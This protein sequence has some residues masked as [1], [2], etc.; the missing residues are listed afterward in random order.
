[1]SNNLIGNCVC[2]YV[3]IRACVKKYLVYVVNS[4]EVLIF[5]QYGPGYHTCWSIKKKTTTYNNCLKLFNVHGSVHPNN[6]V[7]YIS[8]QDAHVTELILSD[9][10]SACFGRHQHPS[11]T[12]VTTASGS[13]YTVLL[14]AAI[15]E[16]LERH[17]QHTQ[18]C[19][20]SF[21]IAA[22]NNTE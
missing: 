15:V 4:V 20:N 2:V 16:E 22:V 21:T 1:M 18:T 17:P 3:Y 6:I 10:C 11:V 19:F 13:R 8:Q 12:T 7:V 14:T 5:M 9:N